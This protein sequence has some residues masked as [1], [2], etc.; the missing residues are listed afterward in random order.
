M[1]KMWIHKTGSFKKAKDF[2]EEYYFNMSNAERM[3]MVQLL[4]E[5]YFKL[6]GRLKDEGRKGLRR[7]VKIIQ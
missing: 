6:K 4:R 5:Q 1:K 7:S 2:D 3:N